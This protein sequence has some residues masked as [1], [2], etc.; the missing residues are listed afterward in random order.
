MFYIRSVRIV[1]ELSL[2]D[3]VA[4]VRYVLERGAVWV[5]LLCKVWAARRIPCLLASIAV[6]RRRDQ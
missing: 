5:L 3:R 6:S 4:L 2:V 1:G